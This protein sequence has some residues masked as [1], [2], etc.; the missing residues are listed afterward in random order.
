[1][2]QCALKSRALPVAVSKW[3][4]RS[5]S[6]DMADANKAS[7][8]GGWASPSCAEPGSEPTGKDAE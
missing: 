4:G 8:D 3:Q 2:T 6:P 5:A 1:M 7:E